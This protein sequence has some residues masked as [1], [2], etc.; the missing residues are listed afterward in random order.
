MTL[1]PASQWDDSWESGGGTGGGWDLSGMDWIS[2][3]SGLIFNKCRERWGGG[4]TAFGL[5]PTSIPSLPLFLPWQVKKVVR[6]T[7]YL[8]PEILRSIISIIFIRQKS[9]KYV[10]CISLSYFHYKVQHLPLILS[11]F[12]QHSLRLESG[13]QAAPAGSESWIFLRITECDVGASVVF[14]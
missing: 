8:R 4:R 3:I 6:L 12:S 5:V 7:Y 1:W 14:S 11:V 13:D 10:S 9:R 2:N